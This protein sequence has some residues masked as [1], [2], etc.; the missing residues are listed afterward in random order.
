LLLQEATKK[1]HLAICH[2]LRMLQIICIFQSV[3]TSGSFKHLH[4]AICHHFWKQETS[5]SYNLLPL[6]EATNI[7]ILQSVAA[8][9]SN[10]SRLTHDIG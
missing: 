9:G 7:S 5:P 3:A 8:S 10:N 6:L 2:H 1:L 4:C